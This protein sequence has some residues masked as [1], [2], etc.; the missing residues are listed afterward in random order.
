MKHNTRI[1]S[2]FQT[3]SGRFRCGAKTVWMGWARV[4]RV[5]GADA[6]LKGWYKLHRC[7]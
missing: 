7:S 1:F 3:D 4:W 6:G 2:G 5:W